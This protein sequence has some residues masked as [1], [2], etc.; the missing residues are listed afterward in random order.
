MLVLAQCQS[1]K[2]LEFHGELYLCEVDLPELS[3]KTALHCL[4]TFRKLK[5]ICILQRIL[6]YLLT[7]ESLT[8][9]PWPLKTRPTVAHALMY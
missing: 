3:V 8:F 5:P 7:V 9:L 6:Q 2:L 4:T 1:R